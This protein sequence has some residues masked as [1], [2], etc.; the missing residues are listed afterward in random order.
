[1]WEHEP[2]QKLTRIHQLDRQI[3][4]LDI[5]P[6]YHYVQNH[7]K[8]MIQSRENGQKSKFGQF[9]F[10]DFEFKYLQIASFSGK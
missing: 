1:M 7:G 4:Q 6:T 5:M 9:F 2:D 10:D 8:L 3:E